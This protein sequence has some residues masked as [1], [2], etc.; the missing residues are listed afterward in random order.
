M[1]AQR[2]LNG[3]QRLLAFL[4]LLLYLVTGQSSVTVPFAWYALATTGITLAAMAMTRASAKQW[5]HPVSSEVLAT[6]SMLPQAAGFIAGA[7]IANQRFSVSRKAVSRVAPGAVKR[8]YRILLAVLAV[9][10]YR[11]LAWGPSAV[12]I[13]AAAGT[14]YHAALLVLLLRHVGRAESLAPGPYEGL[15]P[16]EL[17][18]YVVGR[19]SPAPLCS[20]LCE[21]LCSDLCEGILGD[22]V[23]RS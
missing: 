10:G 13:C 1:R 22:P 20:D 23:L 12:V 18:R 2:H 17:Y 16:A 21:D 9:G 5:H 7:V 8:R 6:A 19:F 15:I 14:C 11:L 3:S 4:V